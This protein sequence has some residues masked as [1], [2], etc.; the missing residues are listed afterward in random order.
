MEVKNEKFVTSYDA[1]EILKK[2]SKE[3]DLNYEQKNAFD[4]LSKFCKL[5]EKDIAAM[6]KELQDMGKLS[7]RH[8]I[9]I[10]EMLP[11]DNDDL[12]LL[13]ANER[14][15]L[16]DDEKSKVLSIVKKHSK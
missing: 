7:D 2:R 10:V 9:S 8:V 11:E 6:V 4:Y 15:V 14:V 3:N 13:F 1:R 5:P 16:S 12:R